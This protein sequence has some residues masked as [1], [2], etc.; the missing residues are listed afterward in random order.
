MALN[1]S[2]TFTDPMLFR[3]LMEGDSDVAKYIYIKFGWELAR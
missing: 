3:Q 2:V 1:C